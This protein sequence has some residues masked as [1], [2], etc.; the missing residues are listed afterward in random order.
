MKEILK[1]RFLKN[2]F[3]LKNIDFDDFWKKIEKNPEKIEILQKMED[4]GGEVEIIFFDAKNDEF[5]L[6]DASV[7]SPKWRR[8]MCYDEESRKNRKKFPPENSAQKF[9]EEIGTK[10]LSEAEYLFLQSLWDFDL[11]T[12]SWLE[13]PPEIRDLG[14]AIFG[15][16]RFGRTFFY[17]NGAESYYASRG[18]RLILKI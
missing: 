16:K 11:K 13:T 5:W 1:K 17:H 4:T 15:D 12:S 6:V 9:A 2:R 7:E 14:G 18:F 3:H 10:L 8:G